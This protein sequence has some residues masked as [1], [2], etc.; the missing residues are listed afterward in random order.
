MIARKIGFCPMSTPY[1]RENSV[2]DI[3]SQVIVPGVVVQP[4]MASLEVLFYPSKGGF[5]KQYNGDAFA[6]EHGSWN[7]A[8][9]AG[10]EVIRI[11]MRDGHA[12]DGSYE[13]FLTGFVTTDCQVWRSPRLCNHSRGQRTLRH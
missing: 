2:G 9:R 13:E 11:P 5:P 3:T 4:H 1:S 12:S 10:Y 6:A 8:N 7:R